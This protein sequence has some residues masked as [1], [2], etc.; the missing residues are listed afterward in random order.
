MFI[1]VNHG[2]NTTADINKQRHNLA[3]GKALLGREPL[4]NLGEVWRGQRP[5]H[6]SL[7]GGLGAGEARP[8][9]PAQTVKFART[10]S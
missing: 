9:T 1:H 6:T 8:Q 3:L 4:Y 10:M 2:Y 5:L 7:G